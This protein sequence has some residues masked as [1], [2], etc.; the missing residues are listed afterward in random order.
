[1]FK[2]L[3]GDPHSYGN[4]CK[5]EISNLPDFRVTHEAI[6]EANGQTVG[7]QLAVTVI[8]RNRVHVCGIRGKNRVTLLLLGDSPAI[9]DAVCVEAY[10]KSVEMDIRGSVLT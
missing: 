4:L 5:A 10:R 6:A 2:C 1:M 3:R 8:L 7:S 9:V